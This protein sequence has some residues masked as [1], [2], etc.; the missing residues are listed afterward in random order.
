MIHKIVQIPVIFHEDDEVCPLSRGEPCI[1]VNEDGHPYFQ[2]PA[3]LERLNDVPNLKKL[4]GLNGLRPPPGY[5]WNDLTPGALGYRHPY[6]GGSIASAATTGHA[7][8]GLGE[9]LE[10]T[11]R[12]GFQHDQGD[13]FQLPSEFFGDSR[14]DLDDDMDEMED[15]DEDANDTVKPLPKRSEYKRYAKKQRIALQVLNNVTPQQ[16]ANLS[17]SLKSSMDNFISQL[18]LHAGVRI[19]ENLVSIPDI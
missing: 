2:D 16:I 3:D 4:S 13:G 8:S 7:D 10:G 14:M 15:V 19:R 18:E 11:N 12:L 1:H 17:P 6:E 9:S 5:S